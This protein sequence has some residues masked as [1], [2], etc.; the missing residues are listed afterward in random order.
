MWGV[1]MSRSRSAGIASSCGEVQAALAGVDGV[2]QAVVIAREDRPGDKRL[3]GYVTGTA[4]PAAVRAE[5]GERLP[6]YMVPA[7]VVVL[8]AL[9]LTVNGKL[10]NRALPA[11]EYTGV[12]RYR[13]P[14]TR[15][16]RSWP[17]SMPR[18]W[19]WSGSGS[20][21]RSSSWVGTA[22]CRCRWW[23]GRGR[24]VWCVG[25][26]TF[27][28]SRRWR[29]WPGWPGW[30][31]VPAGVVDEGMGAVVATPIMRWLAGDGGPGRAVQPD[32]GG[33]GPGGGERGRCGGGGAGVAGSACHVAAA[34]RRRR[35]RGVGAAVPEAGSVDARGCVQTGGGVVRG[36]VGGGAVAVEPGGRGDAERAVGGFDGPVGVDR[37]PFGC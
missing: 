2:E 37:S 3:V 12:D 6:G 11:P 8:E 28:S 16:R 19:G 18:C 1:P 35:R 36:G 27:S 33:A 14:A 5:L 32:H 23:R 24:P 17:A 30:P 9:P 10:D 20:T 34:R 4:D 31:T 25:R 15:S 22:F 7:A 29:G 26:V 21:T 13:A